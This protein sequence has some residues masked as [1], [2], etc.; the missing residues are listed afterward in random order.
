LLAK[1][2]IPVGHEP[3]PFPAPSQN[4]PR[5]TGHRER[6]KTPE[7]KLAQRKSA[8]RFGVFNG[9]V[10]FT[11]HQLSRADALVWLALYR[12]TKTNGIAQTGQAD[13]ARRVGVHAGTIKRAIARLRRLGL[14][15]VVFRG[16]LRRGPSA[17]RVHSLTNLT[18]KGAPA[19]SD[20]GAF[21]TGNQE[22][23]RS[24]SQKGPE[25]ATGA[26]SAPSPNTDSAVVNQGSP[27]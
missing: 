24:P 4:G 26:C 7:G 20:Q 6:N 1:R 21:C 12:D 15:T 3:P 19:L 16:S 14:L 10:D 27:I 8:D 25:L 18:D 17:Y 9:F 13:L 2:L 23:R 5:P 11:M 22:R